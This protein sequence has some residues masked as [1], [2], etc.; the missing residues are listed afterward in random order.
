VPF[1]PDG[2]SGAVFLLD[3]AEDAI[4]VDVRLSEKGI[5]IPILPDVPDS[6]R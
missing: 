2:D 5:G 1:E 4:R 3:V 6:A